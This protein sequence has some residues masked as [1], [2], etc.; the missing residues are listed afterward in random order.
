MIELNYC[1]LA[2]ADFLQLELCEL[3]TIPQAHIL[4]AFLLSPIL[5]IYQC[6][7]TYNTR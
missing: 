1:G 2:L 3:Q 5:F 6:D 4:R 7:S